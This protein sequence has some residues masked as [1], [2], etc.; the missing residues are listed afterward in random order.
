[1]LRVQCL[2]L[3]VSGSMRNTLGVVKE[4]AR[5]FVKTAS[6]DDEFLLLTVSTRPAAI[7]EFTTDTETLEESIALTRPGGS[8][9]SSIRSI[10]A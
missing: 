9:R 1:M 8:R 10:S 6:P 3:D 2:V 5:A 4:G 7:S